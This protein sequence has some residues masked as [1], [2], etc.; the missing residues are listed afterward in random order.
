MSDEYI[1]HLLKAR[2]KDYSRQTQR[3]CLAIDFICQ[4][5]RIADAL[6]STANSHARTEAVAESQLELSRD[7]LEIDKVVAQGTASLEQTLA[8]SV[9]N[10][11]NSGGR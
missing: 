7:K 8:A 2:E 11:Q 5:G 10:S 1:Q 3:D 6:E 9:R 4:V